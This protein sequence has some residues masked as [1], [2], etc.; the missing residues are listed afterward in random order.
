MAPHPPPFTEPPAAL[1][2]LRLSALGDVTHMVPVVRSIQDQWPHTR[3]LWCIGAFEHKLLGDLEGVEFA[4]FRKAAGL[5]AYTDLRRTLAARRFDALLHAQ[6]AMRANLASLAVRA[7]LRVGY[8]RA[9][10]KDLHGLF[11]NRRIPAQP[12]QH[13]LDSFF[14]FAE[15]LGVQRRA[16]R[17]DIPIPEA[18]QAFAHRHVPDGAPTLVISPCSSHRLRNWLPERYAAVAD[19]AIARHGYRVL[20]MGGPSAPEREMGAAI[21]AHMRQRAVNLIGQ[22]TL[23]Q[24]LATLARAE[25]VI[26]PDSGP[27]HMATAV[28]TPVIGLHAASNPQRSGPYLSRQ[29]CVDRYDAAAR[30]EL[31]KPA[32]ELRWGTK[33]ERPGVMELITVED[34]VAKLDALVAS[35]RRDQS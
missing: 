9:R 15:L 35:L 3:L 4:V 27:M 16:L 1:C 12:Q 2:I 21:E 20:L 7:R 8:D 26:S 30:R 13:V 34:V 23:K 32:A 24:L 14:S 11:I 33:I 18:A 5:R 17:W 10:S 31:G 28:G 22:D 19:H 29:W 6:V 25:V